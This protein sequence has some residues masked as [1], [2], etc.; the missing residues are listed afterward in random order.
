[1][2]LRVEAEGG[3]QR[4]RCRVVVPKRE[5]TNFAIKHCVFV[6]IVCLSAQVVNFVVIPM[7]GFQEPNQ[8]LS[9][10]AVGSFHP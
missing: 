9:R 2:C 3:N 8:I 7:L 1:M 6:L 5:A 4:Q 10:V